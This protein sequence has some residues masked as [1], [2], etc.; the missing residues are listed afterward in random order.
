[1]PSL[2]PLVRGFLTSTTACGRLMPPPDQWPMRH[3]LLETKT[4]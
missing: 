1:M 2:L 3:R 4:I